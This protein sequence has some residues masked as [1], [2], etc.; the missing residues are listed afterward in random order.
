MRRTQSRHRRWGGFRSGLR[1]ICGSAFGRRRR[2]SRKRSAARRGVKAGLVLF[3][4]TA[5]GRG[6]IDAQSLLPDDDLVVGVFLVPTVVGAIAFAAFTAARADR[7]FVAGVVSAFWVG[8]VCSILAFNADMVTTLVGFNHEAHV[9][10]TMPKHAG[11]S[12]DSFL[13]LHIGDHLAASMQAVK[14][15]P[16]IAVLLGSIASAIGRVGRAHA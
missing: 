1:H 5:V 9:L 15:L 8:L 10:G 4:V 11:I 7:S 13:D 6:V 16:V 14:N 12:V 3:V 2:W